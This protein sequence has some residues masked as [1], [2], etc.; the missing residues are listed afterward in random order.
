MTTY[1]RR[2][3][4]GAF[5]LIG[6]LMVWWV[7]GIYSTYYPDGA[8]CFSIEFSLGDFRL[9]KKLSEVIACS[10]AGTAAVAGVL[11]LL[12]RGARWMVVF[13]S[14]ATA[15]CILGVFRTVKWF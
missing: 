13:G 9:G 12:T 7:S 11:M 4:A 6:V 5:S 1:H 3:F 15:V 10:A 8:R 14:V 2:L